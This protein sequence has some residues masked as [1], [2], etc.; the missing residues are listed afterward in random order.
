M[1]ELGPPPLT[2]TRVLDLSSGVAGPYA[3]KL[4][5]DAG[6]EVIKIESPSGDHMRRWTATGADLGGDDGAFFRYLNASKRSVVLSLGNAAGR[7][8]FL[9]LSATADLVVEDF[10]PGRMDSLGLGHE[11]QR[12]RNPALAMLSI[13]PFGADGPWRDRA[14]NE[15]TLQAWVGSTHTRGVPNEEPVSVAGW[16]G[17]FVTG[18]FAAPAAL[19][20]LE[21]AR[22]CG[23]GAH[24]DIAIFE[25]MLLSFQQYRFIFERFEPGFPVN[26]EIEIPSIEPAKDGMVG[27]AV[28]TGQQ[29]KDLCLLIEQPQFALIEEFQSFQGRFAKR[30]EVWEMIRGYTSKHTMAEI[31]ER[32]EMLRVPAAPVVEGARV[33]ELDHFRERGV[34][35]DNPAGFRQPRVPYRLYDCKTRPFEMAPALGA[36]S[37]AVLGEARRRDPAIDTGGDARV[38]PLAGMRVIDLSAFWA[39]PVTGNSLAALGADVIKI[40]SI[41]RPDMMRFSSGFVRDTLWEWSPIYHG[42]N[43]GKRGIT[44]DLTTDAGHDLLGRLAEDADIVIENFSARVLENLGI[45]WDWL[46]AL[47]PKAILMRLPAF[48]LD[49]PWR[50]RTGF[51]MTIEQVSGLGWRTGHPDGPP[52]IPRGPCDPLAGAHALFAILLALRDRER[53]GVGQ[54]IEV[55]L[56]EVGLNAAAEQV[57]EFSAYGGRIGRQGNRSRNAAPQGIY[58]ARS[59]DTWVALSV[60]TDTQWQGLVRAFGAPDWARAP[61]L[62]NAPGRLA[63]HDELDAHLSRAIGKLERDEAVA[64][65]L[66]EAV[67]VAPIIL[68]TLSGENPQP[69]ERGF[70]QE[71]E[72]PLTGKTPYASFPARFDGNFIPW[73]RPSP[74][75]GQHNDEV[76]T[77]LLG[78]SEQELSELREAGVIGERPSFV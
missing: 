17:E 1:P 61:A 4:L 64:R 36:D 43:P 46:H 55:P 16:L 31:L 23:R 47:N 24:V 58:R 44:L 41:G 8:S 34:Y 13:T 49:G 45:G 21:T 14:A 69:R 57:I 54:L 5:A 71:L 30:E 67:P 33:P 10:A 78:L 11:V 37:E 9:E 42:A 27:L 28:V 22:L 6:A 68:P 29:W 2:G 19:S 74:S 77:E 56:V 52:L 3:T 25:A 62:A 51:A 70:F 20:A 72:H 38:A 63:A 32:A 48:G 60:E 40:E 39:G 73:Q 18:A 59:D 53:T 26:R 7:E 12:E 76:L 50:D 66:A 15:F 75:L 35:V 65:L